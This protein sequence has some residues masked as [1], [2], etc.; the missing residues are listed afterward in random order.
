MTSKNGFCPVAAGMAPAR[1]RDVCPE[2]ADR[3]NG[4][5]TARERELIALIARGMSNKVIAHTMGISPNTVR[6][7]VGNIMRKYKL[8]NRVQ[9]AMLLMPMLRSGGTRV[10]RPSTT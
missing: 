9:I 10:S 3:S 5:L 7:H 8:R 6:A 2:A 4:Q 1:L